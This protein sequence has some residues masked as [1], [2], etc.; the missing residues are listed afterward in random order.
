MDIDTSVSRGR[1][2]RT[3]RDALIVSAARA[4]VPTDV[5]VQVF[6]PLKLRTIQHIIRESTNES[7]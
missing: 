5:I 2:V 3:V 1:F 6:T 7:N 4:G